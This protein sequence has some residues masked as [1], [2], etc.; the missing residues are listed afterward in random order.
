MTERPVRGRNQ[1]LTS[2]PNSHC[3]RW[4]E[5]ITDKWSGQTFSSSTSNESGRMLYSVLLPAQFMVDAEK[6][7]SVGVMDSKSGDVVAAARYSV[8]PEE[9]FGTL[10]N[11][12]A[13]LK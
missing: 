6:W 8:P 7:D 4:P 10:R 12:A 11:C 1:I 5:D 3:S 13:E 9:F 2:A